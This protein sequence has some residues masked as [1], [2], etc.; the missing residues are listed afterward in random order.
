MQSLILVVNY[1]FFF[2]LFAGL[3]YN[4]HLIVKFNLLL[5]YFYYTG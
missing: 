5:F 3:L 2:I 1:M 4:V